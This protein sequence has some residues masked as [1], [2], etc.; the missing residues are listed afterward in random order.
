MSY[1]YLRLTASP[2][3]SYEDLRLT[4]F[5]CIMLKIRGEARLHTMGACAPVIIIY[6]LNFVKQNVQNL[7]D[8][9]EKGGCAPIVTLVRFLHLHLFCFY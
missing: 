8:Q 9:M 4:G 1:E 2:E 5:T 6:S 3:P 7:L